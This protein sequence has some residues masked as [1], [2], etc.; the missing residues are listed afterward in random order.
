MVRLTRIYTRTG[1]DG[2]TG[3]GDGSRVRK[4]SPRIEAYG[5]VDELNAVLGLCAE[6]AAGPLLERLRRLQ[7]DLFDLGADLCQ[8]PGSG[9]PVLVGA[10]RVARLE[11]WIDEA[12]ERLAP[13]TSFILPGG[14][15]LAAHLHLARTVCRR[16][17]R[18]VLALAE[19]GPSTRRAALPQPA[20]GPVLRLVARRGRRPGGPVGATRDEARRDECAA[21]GR[22]WA[23]Q[24]WPQGLGAHGLK[25][26]LTPGRGWRD[27]ASRYQLVHALALVLTGP[28]GAAARRGARVAGAA[29]PGRDVVFSGTLYAMALA[30]PL[31]GR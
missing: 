15:P 6:L 18:R 29:V 25:E 30:P 8:P 13:L 10:A 19:R 11:G 3:L 12:N 24:A 27:T 26:R 4:T 28:A 23:R 14:G 17:E 7:Q 31:A 9:K 1:D 20:V 22:C 2:T 21:R 5:C 16:A